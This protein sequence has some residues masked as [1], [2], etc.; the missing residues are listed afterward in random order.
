MIQSISV[1]NFKNETLRM[2]LRHPEET[3]LIIY[4][5]EGIGGGKAN[6]NVSDIA[7]GD[8]SW[9]NSSRTPS[10]NIVFY[11]KLIATAENRSIEEVRHNVVYRYFPI[12]K[13]LRLIFQ[14]D[15]REMYIDGYVESNEIP[16]FSSEE[17]TQVSIICPDPYFYQVGSPATI[18][19]GATPLFEFPFW[20]D[21]IIPK[22]DSDP[23]NDNM[24]SN[25]DLR[26]PINTNG[27]TQ[28]SS[29]GETI[30]GWYFKNDSS[31]NATVNIQQ[32]EMTVS[33]YESNSTPIYWYN[34]FGSLENGKDYCASYLDDSGLHTMSFHLDRDDLSMPY[35]NDFDTSTDHIKIRIISDAKSPFYRFEVYIIPK[36]TETFRIQAVKVEKGLIQTL[37]KE[38]NGQWELIKKPEPEKEGNNPTIEFG[39]IIVET[40]AIIDYEGSADVGLEIT[41]NV[42]GGVGDITLFDI[43][44]NKTLKIFADK[45]S[46]ISGKILDDGDIIKI[47]TE[48]GHKKVVL[49]RG[50]NEI[51]I[52]G[53]IDKDSDWFQLT[54]GSNIFQFSAETGTENLVV[55][56]SYNTAYLGV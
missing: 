35:E 37:A 12:K 42:N 47:Y 41:I 52:T 2:E 48:R 14:T 29:S 15:K 13:K 16:I 22:P 17:Y 33:Q 54:P 3:G 32:K 56:F 6:I 38:E 8:G 28:Y 40:R 26:N 30:N 44:S 9:Y 23:Y 10:R 34:Q 20:D 7:N 51:E 18:F 50:I 5:I 27:L 36:I 53:A 31:G 43:S 11:A 19:A 25:F 21:S 49:I 4:N 55:T 1:I 39:D 45:V 46:N 24:I